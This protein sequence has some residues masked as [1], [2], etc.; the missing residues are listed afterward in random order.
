MPLGSKDSKQILFFKPH[1]LPQSRSKAYKRC[2]LWARE[3]IYQKQ[4][5][6]TLVLSG[7]L[8]LSFSLFVGGQGEEQV[9]L[10]SM[11]KTTLTENYLWL[12]ILSISIFSPQ[13]MMIKILVIYWPH[14]K[15]LGQGRV[16]KNREEQS[17]TRSLLKRRY[18]LYRAAE[19]I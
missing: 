11:Q 19:V 3:T 14:P 2:S 1:R 9:R 4:K 8:P 12:L 10:R 15:C 13:T 16:L 5:G 18:F 17:Q 7:L 6:M